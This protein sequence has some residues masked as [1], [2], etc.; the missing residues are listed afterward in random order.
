MSD[1]DLLKAQGFVLS[2]GFLYQYDCQSAAATCQ[3][4]YK[5]WKEVEHQ[6]PETSKVEIRHNRELPSWVQDVGIVDRGIVTHQWVRRILDNLNT[7]RVAANPEAFVPKW[8]TDIQIAQVCAWVGH[9]GDEEDEPIGAMWVDFGHK[10]DDTSIILRGTATRII[11]V[12]PTLEFG[13]GH[14]P[15]VTPFYRSLSRQPLWP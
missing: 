8:G 7:L 11:L 9:G 4:W 1:T 6:L 5:A 15:L 2:S 10:K 14:G 3:N 12:G 13:G